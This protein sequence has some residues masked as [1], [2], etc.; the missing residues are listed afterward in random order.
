ML[1]RLRLWVRQMA[2]Q[3]KNA[4]NLDVLLISA[5][6]G[7]GFDKLEDRL[8]VHMMGEK[9][10]IYVMGRTN[11]GKSTFV[12]RFLNHIGYAHL[13]K[14]YMKQGVGGVTRSAVPG[15]TLTFNAF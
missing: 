8:K 2:R 7:F 1:Y 11:S 4:A 14:V 3:A 9:K 10:W 13:G 6:T 12:N 5:A 15:T